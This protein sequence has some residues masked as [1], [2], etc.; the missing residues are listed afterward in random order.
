MLNFRPK[1]NDESIVKDTNHATNG[2]QPFTTKLTS[3]PGTTSAELNTAISDCLW[4]DS[5]EWTEDDMDELILTCQLSSSGKGSLT[6]P[7]PPRLQCGVS[8]SQVLVVPETQLTQMPSRC[9]GTQI[10]PQIQP[11]SQS[12]QLLFDEEKSGVNNNE[13]EHAQEVPEQNELDK[14]E[15]NFDEDDSLLASAAQEFELSQEAMAKPKCSPIKQSNCQ[16]ND[17]FSFVKPLKSG[18]NGDDL[19]ESKTKCLP[20][21][22]N[23][24]T[25]CS[26]SKNSPR[27]GNQSNKN[28]NGRSTCKEPLKT[29]LLTTGNSSHFTKIS[30]REN[31]RKISPAKR[32]DTKR[33]T[34]K[35]ASVSVEQFYNKVPTTKTDSKSLLVRGNSSTKETESVS[36]LT[37]RERA[38]TKL[39][40]RRTTPSQN[41][42]GTQFEN[43]TRVY[44][45]NPQNNART[46]QRANDRSSSPLRSIPGNLSYPVKPPQL[47]TNLEKSKESYSKQTLAKNKEDQNSSVKE[48]N[49]D[50]ENE[51]DF[52]LCEDDFAALLDDFNFDGE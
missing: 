21:S 39:S 5:F 46:Q 48:N 38:R 27:K 47:Q 1:K 12:T 14:W 28:S 35:T 15:L 2:H 19:H 34:G 37:P 7:D 43:L 13:V 41:K 51:L 8:P 20:A 49:K 26:I 52:L 23:S 36:L 45:N 4:D 10:Q 17:G 6:V 11:C 22:R 9:A 42:A 40:L 50:Q 16:N 24:N 29:S 31:P 33:V 25:N 30:K 18:K 3:T 44:E 32:N